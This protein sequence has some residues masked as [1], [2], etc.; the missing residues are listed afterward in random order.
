MDMV[1][2]NHRLLYE[3]YAIGSKLGDDIRPLRGLKQLFKWPKGRTDPVLS[4][5]TLWSYNL[6]CRN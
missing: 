4:S 3:Y 6:A 1:Y 5:S 2:I